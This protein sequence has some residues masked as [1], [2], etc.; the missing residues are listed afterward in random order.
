M[1]HFGVASDEVAIE[2]KKRNREGTKVERREIGR[3]SVAA[4]VEF[5]E[6]SEVGWDSTFDGHLVVLISNL[7]YTSSHVLCLLVVSNLGT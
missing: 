2:G 1:G 5:E 6:M 4:G 3:E 7:T